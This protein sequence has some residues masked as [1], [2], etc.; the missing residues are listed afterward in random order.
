[1]A[2]KWG[3][4]GISPLFTQSPVTSATPTSHPAL[5]KVPSVNDPSQYGSAPVVTTVPGFTSNES[6][7]W[8]RVANSFREGYDRQMREG[9]LMFVKVDQEEE[10]RKDNIVVKIGPNAKR[11]IVTYTVA[12]LHMV[13][14]FLAKEAAARTYAFQ[15]A[16]AQVAASTAAGNRRS[17]ADQPKNSHDR[18]LEKAV[19]IQKEHLDLDRVV[20]RWIFDG[21]FSNE[22]EPDHH[23]RYNKNRDN[24]QRTINNYRKGYTMVKRYWTGPIKQGTKL[25]ILVR[26]VDRAG[27]PTGYTLNPD[28]MI[29]TNPTDNLMNPPVN[30]V[31]LIPYADSAQDYPP[32]SKYRYNIDPFPTRDQEVNTMMSRTSEEEDEM[33]ALPGMYAKVIFIGTVAE[34]VMENEKGID[35]IDDVALLG[36]TTTISN[37]GRIAIHMDDKLIN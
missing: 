5:G 32:H 26:H 31:Q 15:T 4:N 37:L 30:A 17:A 8:H 29:S 18:L 25:Y 9:D 19:N 10:K 34:P 1:M 12:N 22:R 24:L 35:G 11:R 13:N 21:V 2:S 27:L 16:A 3:S 33:P 36:S 6:I 7:M 20:N 14:F 28:D 23:R